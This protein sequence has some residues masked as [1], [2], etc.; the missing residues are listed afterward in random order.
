VTA[1]FD[2]DG[3]L[4][5]VT[6]N[7][8]G[9][10]SFLR[11]KADGTFNAAVDYPTGP[12]PTSIATGD[13]NH[14]SFLDIVVNDWT[15]VGGFQTFSAL[16][17]NGDGSFGPR[18]SF[19]P[20]SANTGVR[21]AD[22]D[23]DSKD[24][25]LAI[26]SNNSILVVYL[27]NGDGTFRSLLP[28][29]SI[30][31]GSTRECVIRDF[32]RD[33]KPDVAVAV[34]GSTPRVGIL[35]G[36]GDGTLTSPTFYSAATDF[37]A[38]IAAGDLN[39]DGFIDL[40]A[41]ST[42]SG[43][44]SYLRGNGDGTFQAHVDTTSP[45][46]DYL[47]VADVDAD[48]KLDVL[49]VQGR[50]SG[51]LSV[52]RGNGD[53]TLQLPR[54]FA[55]S[56]RAA[57]VAAGELNGDGKLDLIIPDN[58][59]NFIS[60][61]LNRTGTLRISGTVTDTSN[62]GPLAGANVIVTSPGSM[63]FAVI[64]TT[65]GTYSV[66]GLASNSNYTL[67]PFRVNYAFTPVQQAF[68][69]L[70]SDQTA[71]FAGTLLTYSISGIV[72]DAATLGVPGV[73]ITLS[74]GMSASTTTGGDGRYIF[75]SVPGNG[76]YTITPSLPQSV[77][78]PTSQTISNLSSDRTANF[79][80]SRATYTIHASVRDPNSNSAYLSEPNI[81]L[82]GPV[83]RNVA[84]MS[85]DF[86][87]LPVA[88]NYTVTVS[89]TSLP[90]TNF[91]LQSPL[92]QSI[93]NLSSDQ[94][95][96]F[97]AKALEF[98][99]GPAPGD[100]VTGDF[101]NDGKIDVV[102]VS[103][104]NSQIF[105]LPGN[106][107]GT[108]QTGTSF[109]GG[110]FQLSPIAGDFNHDGKLDLAVVDNGDD[111]VSV[112]L[113]NGDGTF[114]ADVRYHVGT[115]PIKVTALDLNGDNKLDLVTA[116]SSSH[117]VSVLIGNGD[118][119]FRT[120]VNYVLT[121]TPG[122]VTSGDFNSDGKPDVVAGK[123][124][125]LGDGAGNLQTPVV[126]SNLQFPSSAATGDFDRD[127]HL[128][129]AVSA[130][131]FATSLLIYF[132]NGDATFRPPITYTTTYFSSSVRA[133]DFNGDGF[134]D[135]ALATNFDLTLF[136]GNS[137]GSFQDTSIYFHGNYFPR[138]I[139]VGDFNN[140][141]RP[142]VI[143]TSGK[144]VIALNQ[145]QTGLQFTSSTYTANEGDQAAHLTLIRTG[146][147]ASSSTVSYATMGDPFFVPCNV[148]NG[149]ALTRCDF[150]TT[151]D[152]VTFAPGETQKTITIPL[153]DDAYAE[154]NES[155][156]LNVT[157]TTGGVFIGKSTITVTI[158]DNDVALGPNP[159]FTTPFFVRQQY[160][161]FLSRE[162]EPSGFN[163]WS[164]VLNG[165][166]DPNNVDPA[167]PSAGCD[168]IT[169]SSSFF[170]SQEF[171]LKGFFVYRFY[172]ASFG[173]LPTYNEIISDMR[174]VTGA[175]P[176]EVFAKRTAFADNWVNRQE[177]W[178]Y[179]MTSNTTFVSILMN[180]Y[181]LAQITT[182]N[183]HD[184]EGSQKVIMTRADLVNQLDSGTLPRALALR[185]VVESDEV[186]AAEF[187]RAF[188]AM[189]YFG[190]LRRDPDT[191]GFNAWLNYLNSHPSD[192]RTMVNGFVNSTE[193]RLRFGNPTP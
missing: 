37:I 156:Q 24:D 69:N 118:G 65:D 154:G 187:N 90:F 163:A 94:S 160:L 136:T 120:A 92:T 171:Q 102:V 122:Y 192:F 84:F 20:G 67:T 51:I 74:G 172:R 158:A 99:A 152:T 116:N 184:P 36:N 157:E 86:T 149:V 63:D 98:A 146:N 54:Q 151:I 162:P 19:G 159:I 26:N 190:Y 176:A 53:G 79:S 68:T 14:D 191:A 114:Q 173:R 132:G 185:A 138:S 9:S 71:N 123:S 1:D 164:G 193:Y 38:Q 110:T 161:D 70:N 6:V 166:P 83:S 153:I 140:D 175:T 45:G 88:G 56:L 124:L 49:T 25:I 115:E 13:F 30:L 186:A 104:G 46:S 111:D 135:L 28:A 105:M 148:V 97:N 15:A 57:A 33:G 44:I 21:T 139:G 128:D 32:N 178:F 8:S 142:D 60:V 23:G 78:G 107:D 75:T 127:G 77:F 11:G 39:G 93:T 106:G 103:S 35:L 43:R 96:N 117:D 34:E 72:R 125:L 180:R 130:G 76:T 52:L 73:T 141:G 64:T 113:G 109:S 134:L 169:V 181:G 165:C 87:S 95:V 40:I 62:N 10:I 119:T 2:R 108:L 41:T 7:N 137:D 42:F 143:F 155:F 182:P 17:G 81:T 4:D 89:Q 66:T 22:F 55:V 47:A 179:N 131:Q 16:L 174:S 48:G 29:N 3:R 144:L 12:Q 50:G 129:L 177:F 59:G 189:Q 183:P 31:P 61:L 91:I 150:A 145:M 112:R 170:G 101:N 80:I 58:T 168:R 27:S 82:T 85:A 100:S 147:I 167:S 121:D 126:F 18:I 133:A 188:V 5:V